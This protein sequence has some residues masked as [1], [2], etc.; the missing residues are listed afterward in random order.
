MT[1][2]AKIGSLL[3]GD[4]FGTRGQFEPEPVRTPVKRAKTMPI[5]A[6][7]TKVKKK[8]K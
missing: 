2:R 7:K 5:A 1:P 4:P 8:K 6:K 3:K